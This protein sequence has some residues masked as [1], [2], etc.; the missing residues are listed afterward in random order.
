MSILSYLVRWSGFRPV[1]C[2]APALCL[3]LLHGALAGSGGQALFDAP[4]DPGP[5]R[6]GFWNRRVGACQQGLEAAAQALAHLATSLWRTSISG[7]WLGAPDQ[8]GEFGL[9]QA[10]VLDQVRSVRSRP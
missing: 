7:S 1:S 4:P 5:K 3:S 8:G 9:G 10:S 2:A 6:R